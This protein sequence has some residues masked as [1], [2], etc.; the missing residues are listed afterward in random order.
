MPN[1]HQ[2]FIVWPTSLA[3]CDVEDCGALTGRTSVQSLQTDV[4]DQPGSKYWT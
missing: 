4:S 1:T 3:R 2:P